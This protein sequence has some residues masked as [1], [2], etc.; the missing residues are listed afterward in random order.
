MT[1][2]RIFTRSVYG[3]TLVYVADAE[4]ARLLANLTGAKTLESRHLTALEGLG[5]TIEQV[6]DPTS[7][8]AALKW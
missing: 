6:P 8:L 1:P 5:F 4:Q 7:N 3:R 2:I